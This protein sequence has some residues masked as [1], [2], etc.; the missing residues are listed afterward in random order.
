MTADSIVAASISITL[1]LLISYGFLYFSEKKHY[2]LAWSL[3][4]LML[5]I[6]YLSRTA[7]LETDSPSVVLQI[8]NYASSI[9]GYWLI[10]KGTLLFFSRSYP[11]FWDIGTGFL[12]VAFICIA[13][14]GI[15]ATAL[16][17]LS[18]VWIIALLS[19]AA[20]TCLK[21]K[22]PQGPIRIILGYTYIFWALSILLY[23]LCKLINVISPSVGYLVAGVV[24][25][26]AYLNMQALYFQSIREEL[27]S[28]EANIRKLVIYDK[29]TGAYSRT[30]FENVLE[31]FLDK[32]LMPATLAMGDFNGLKL[33]NDT[34]GHEKGDELLA[35][36]I[37]IMQETIGTENVIIRWGGDEFIIIMPGVPLDQAGVF[38]NN[39]KNNLKI[40][41]PQTVPID[42]SFGLTVYENREQPLAKMISQAEE[43]MY[44]NKLNESKKSRLAIIEFL[45]KLLWEKDYQTEAHVM[46]L[47]SLV[48]KFGSQIGLSPREIV[49]LVQVAM[50]HDIG[51]IGVP[52][53]ILKKQGDLTPEEWSI[54]KKHSEIGY[55]ITQ[56]SR[57]LAHVSEA[58]LGHHEWWNGKGYPQGL[59]EDEIPLFSRIVSI[60]DSYDVIT[61][62]RP[63]KRAMDPYSALVEINK[64]A[65]KQF[66]PYLVTV[67]N[68]IMQEDL[69]VNDR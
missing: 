66:D 27:E 18:V 22:T 53:E 17:L 29:L 48:S 51:K 43:K 68:K 39:I 6:T 56:S 21:A 24:G 15:S 38:L 25:L 35:D 13:V 23:P 14:Q 50:L 11:V 57:E 46:R 26:L 10:F 63:Y 8:I 19:K 49:E 9:A 28:K 47:K 5:M 40:S 32:T 62:E 37:R 69:V 52:G 33:I 42:I 58:V 4:V 67:F 1:V 61:H 44:S 30:Y 64:C 60:V 41:R 3:S 36:G 31:D 34:F 65:G 12:I 54:M 55:R 7:L 59:K 2:F 45:E 20:M 16:L